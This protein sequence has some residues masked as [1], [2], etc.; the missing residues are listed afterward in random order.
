MAKRRGREEFGGAISDPSIIELAGGDGVTF[1]VATQEAKDGDATVRLPDLEAYKPCDRCDGDW[2]REH[3]VTGG[4]LPHYRRQGETWYSA[5]RA[6]PSCVFGAL[7]HHCT[8]AAFLDGWGGCTIRDLVIL[9]PYL[10]AGVLTLR[11]GI[12]LV[13]F[14]TV[15]ARLRRGI[16]ELETRDRY[17]KGPAVGHQAETKAVGVGF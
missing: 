15:K 8:K 3:E 14:E 4:W 17:P 13:P 1:R 10:R 11:E 7:R 12:E 16:E 6:C 9:W 5:V 2:T